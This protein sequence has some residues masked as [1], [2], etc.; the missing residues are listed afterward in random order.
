MTRAEDA[1]LATGYAGCI[2]RAV[3]RCLLVGVLGLVAGS[4]HAQGTAVVRD[5]DAVV[6]TG[7]IDADA[8]AR[9]I[10]LLQDPAVSRLV[11]TSGGG[12][13]APALDLADAVHARRIDV[14]VPKACLSSCA[15]YVL[16][17]GARK[18]LGRPGVVGWHGTM[19]HVL[20]LQATGQGSWSDEEM[21]E[22]RA[23][24]A[25]EVTFYARLG[26]DGFVGWFA[27]LP[28]YAIDEFYCLSPPDMARFGIHDVTVR[29]PEAAIANALVQPVEVDWDALE[30]LRATTR[31]E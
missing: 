17:A 25:R 6:F 12:L 24:A 13:V 23:L 2:V 9:A 3:F 1:G 22:A 4:L 21:A 5:G 18:V 19:A 10:A 30:S 7:R 31:L 8:A 16:P 28:P 27:K 15:N 20:Y 26:V 29:D 11:I 14:E